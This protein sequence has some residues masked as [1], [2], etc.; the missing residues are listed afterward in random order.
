MGGVMLTQEQQEASAGLIDTRTNC[1][2]LSVYVNV[3]SSTL[4][5]YSL[6]DRTGNADQV[7]SRVRAYGL[8]N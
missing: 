8:E 2:A 5:M 7:V 4:T 6:L 3:G 1:F